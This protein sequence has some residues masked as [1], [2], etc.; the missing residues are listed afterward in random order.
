MCRCAGQPAYQPAASSTVAAGLDRLAAV[1]EALEDAARGLPEA[2]RE[3]AA[4]G[5]LAAAGGAIMGGFM[6]PGAA[7]ELLDLRCLQPLV[8]R[9][10]HGLR[11]ARLGW[12][13]STGP[14]ASVQLKY[15]WLLC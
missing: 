7:E 10:R 3:A 2:A 14:P 15:D 5:V 9:G 1:H 8:S 12:L 11:L 4:V 6:R 13:D